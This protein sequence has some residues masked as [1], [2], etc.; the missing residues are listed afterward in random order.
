MICP[1][2]GGECSYRNQDY[3]AHGYYC[4]PCKRTFSCDK[5]CCGCFCHRLTGM[6]AT[7]NSCVSKLKE[8]IKRLNRRCQEAESAATTKVEEVRKAGPSLGRALAGWAAADCNRK[9]EEAKKTI[10]SM[11]KLSTAEAFEEAAQWLQKMPNWTD[12]GGFTKGWQAAV[13]ALME[14]AEFLKEP[15]S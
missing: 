11:K 8:T 14:R 13:D 3:V 1:S 10:E 5:E 2:C 9:L 15:K 4:D 7:C 12:P 6:P